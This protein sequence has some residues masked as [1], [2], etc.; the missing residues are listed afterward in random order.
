MFLDTREPALQPSAT[1]ILFAGDSS[2]IDDIQT[3]LEVLP[4]CARGQVFIEVA[5]A[6]EIVP[7]TA[8]GRVSVTWLDRSRRSG[9]PGTGERCTSGV[10]LDRAVRAWVEEFFVDRESLVDGDYVFWI[11]GPAGFAYDLRHDLAEAFNAAPSAL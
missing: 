6:S 11:G 2:S 9:R 1:R 7:V 4:I 10:A 3:M 8:P 5:D